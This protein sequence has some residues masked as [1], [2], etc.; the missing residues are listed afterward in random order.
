[1]MKKLF[2]LAAAVTLSTSVLAGNMSDDKDM[3][4]MHDQ[5]HDQMHSKQSF[6]K[7]LNNENMQRLHKEMTQNAVSEPGMD[8]RLQMIT[9][10]EGRAYHEAMKREKDNI[11]G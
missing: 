4:S 1:M 5:M 7:N 2:V 6:E 9:T 10:E 3:K 8:A 11:E